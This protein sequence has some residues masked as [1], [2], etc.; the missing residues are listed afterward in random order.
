MSKDDLIERLRDHVNKR[1][2][3]ALK[4]GAWDMMLEAAAEIERL[5]ARLAEAEKDVNEFLSRLGPRWFLEQNWFPE[6]KR[7]AAEWMEK[8]DE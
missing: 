3:P 1:G 7:A 6:S 8:G 4:N 5:R 2:G